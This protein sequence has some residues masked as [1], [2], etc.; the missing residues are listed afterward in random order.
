MRYVV[1]RRAAL[2]D[3]RAA[4]TSE[5]GRF[6]AEIIN[7][8]SNPKKRMDLSGEWIDNVHRRKPP[9]KNVFGTLKKPRSG[10]HDPKQ[11]HLTCE[12]VAAGAGRRLISVIVVGR[13]S[14]SDP[15]P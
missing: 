11:W 6:E 8:S 15:W 7:T 1:A 4:S 2:A 12:H 13:P 9:E 3:K 14:D 5:V 10:E